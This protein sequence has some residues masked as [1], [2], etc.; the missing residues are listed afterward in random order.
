MFAVRLADGAILRGDLAAARAVEQ[1]DPRLALGDGLDE[2]VR[3]VARGVRGD[4][5]LDP[6]SRVV[7]REEVVEP[8]LDHRLLVVGG[9]DD[10]DGRLGRRVLRDPPL[11]HARERSRGERIPDVRP[12]ERRRRAPEER[13]RHGHRRESSPACR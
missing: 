4:D 1:A 12:R 5:D 2:L 9:D 10:A 6:V 7:E 8:A 11:A 3:A 13:L